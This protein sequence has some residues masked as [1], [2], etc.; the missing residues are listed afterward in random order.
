[1]KQEITRIDLGGVN[2]YLGKEGDGYILFDT[3][4]HMVMDRQFDNR[5][6]RLVEDLEKYGCKP[7]N[8]KLV[9]LTHGDNDHA[10]NAAFI[11][12]KYNAEIAMHRDD[13]ELVDN[14]GIEKVMQSF[15]YKSLIYKAVFLLMKGLIKKASLKILDDFE[16]FVPDIFINEGYSLSEYGFDA[17][18]VHIPGHTPGSI[19][20]LTDEGDLI[21]GDTLT[22]MNKPDIAPNAYDFEALEAGVDRIKTMAVRTVYPGHGQPFDAKQLCAGNR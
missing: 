10:A 19:G 6:D 18:I 8:L 7:G 1:M 9:V 13:L 22:N 11:R 2:C 4:G 12:A 20:I 14:P 21:A 3:G 17:R 15:G 5:R 16:K